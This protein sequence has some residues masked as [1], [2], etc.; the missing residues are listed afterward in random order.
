[1]KMK[2]LVAGLLSVA[3]VSTLLV[4]CGGSKEAEVPEEDVLK[5]AAFE[6]GNGA[7]IWKDIAA[8][9]EEETGVKVD[10]KLSSKIDED[11]QKAFKNKDIP[12]VVYYNLGGSGFT[13][14]MLKE[15]AIADISD[16]YRAIMWS[17][18]D[19]DNLQKWYSSNFNVEVHAYVK[20]GK[21][22]VVNNTYEPQSTTVYRGDGSSFDL[23]LDANEIIWY[24]I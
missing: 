7:Q 6:G 23:D 4:G 5:L 16:V 10:L 15:H 24:E 21:Y 2:K 14:T 12:D 8:A 13:E 1:M 3:M 19:E 22:C 20:N 17:A 11:L 18:H 9:F